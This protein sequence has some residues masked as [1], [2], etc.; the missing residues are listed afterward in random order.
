MINWNGNVMLIHLGQFANEDIGR[1]HPLNNVIIQGMNVDLVRLIFVIFVLTST[2]LKIIR[3]VNGFKR[4]SF[5]LAE[6]SNEFSK[7]K[8]S[9]KSEKRKSF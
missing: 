1:I 2:L 4:Y 7:L 5:L 8:Y 9:S 3:K 6:T